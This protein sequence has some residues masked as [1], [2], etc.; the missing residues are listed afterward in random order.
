MMPLTPRQ[1]ASQVN[2]RP[3]PARGIARSA[4][5]AVPLGARHG[6]AA[7]ALM[8][9]L[10]ETDLQVYRHSGTGMPA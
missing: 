10:G 7:E 5:G 6:V 2:S 4:I 1:D 9:A 8:A 3:G